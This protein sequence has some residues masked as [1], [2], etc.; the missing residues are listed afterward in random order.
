MP[1]AGAQPY[2]FTHFRLAPAFRAGV[3]TFI[4]TGFFGYAQSSTTASP[5][6]CEIS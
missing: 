2:H 3:F 6:C 5:A 1:I 4:T